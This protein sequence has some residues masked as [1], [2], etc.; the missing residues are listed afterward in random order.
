ME[1]WETGLGLRE[2]EAVILCVI[3]LWGIFAARAVYNFGYKREHWTET[4]GLTGG[5]GKIK[6]A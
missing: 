5:R 3:V 4:L 6:T 1:G 2:D